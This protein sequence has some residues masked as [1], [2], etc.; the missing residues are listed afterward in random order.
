MKNLQDPKFDRGMI[1]F[2]EMETKQLERLKALATAYSRKDKNG[3]KIDHASWSA[4]FVQG[5]GKGLT[6]LLHGKPGVG[7]TW[8]A[9]KK[10]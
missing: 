6:F 7:K 2:L 3:K 8:T 10:F 4:D 5:K 9:G 1:K